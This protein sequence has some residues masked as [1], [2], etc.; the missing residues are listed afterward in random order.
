MPTP[1]LGSPRTRET[2]A[3]AG[4]E[5]APRISVSRMPGASGI[6][7]TVTWDLRG[8]F[9]LSAP[10]PHRRGHAPFRSLLRAALDVVRIGD[11]VGADLAEV[12]ID[13]LGMVSSEGMHECI[14]VPSSW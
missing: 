5:R 1:K 4:P 10:L 2:R 14:L 6:A 8:S 12:K 13:S 3:G 11:D 9:L 7:A